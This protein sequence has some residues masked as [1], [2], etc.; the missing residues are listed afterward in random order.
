LAVLLGIALTGKQ[1]S[2]GP[3]HRY[4]QP[5]RLYLLVAENCGAVVQS[6]SNISASFSPMGLFNLVGSLQNL[7][8][9]SAVGDTYPW[10]SV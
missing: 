3:S 4:L 6:W 9:A 1:V 5:I 7:E 10:L 8:S 2:Q